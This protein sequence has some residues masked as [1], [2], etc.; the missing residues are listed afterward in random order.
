VARA[1]LWRIA[2]RRHA[3]DRLGAGARRYGGRWNYPGTPVVYAAG[4]I[5]LAALE[6]FVNAEGVVPRDLVLVRLELPREHSAEAATPAQLPKGWNNVPAGPTSM[7]FGTRWLA[8]K[9]SLV[10]YVPSA[11]VPEEANALLNPKHPEFAG[12]KMVVE[13]GFDY[14]IRMYLPRR[15]SRRPR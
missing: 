4:S 8:A 13:R 14:D 1:V 11:L 2:R 7:A 6:K 9:R 10:L 3:L 5:A 15:R 12:V